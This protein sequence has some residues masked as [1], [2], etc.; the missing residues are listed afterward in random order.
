[1][2]YLG[3]EYAIHHSQSIDEQKIFDVLSDHDVTTSLT[4]DHWTTLSRFYAENMAVFQEEANKAWGGRA[5]RLRDK[6]ASLS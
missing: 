1:M 4:F 6:L 2:L 3:F 5:E